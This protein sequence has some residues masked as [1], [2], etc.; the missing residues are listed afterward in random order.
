MH[1]F[2]HRFEL[3]RHETRSL[4]RADADCVL[5]LL[6]IETECAACRSG[7]SNGAVRS[8]RMKATNEMAGAN[9]H[10]YAGTY[11]NAGD[12]CCEEFLSADA[13]K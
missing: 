7:G 2:H 9:A 11:L 1:A 8:S 13:A 3:R 10:A 4:S 5:H 6:G 12:A